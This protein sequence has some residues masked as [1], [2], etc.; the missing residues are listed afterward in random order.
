MEVKNAYH[1]TEEGWRLSYAD[2]PTGTAERAVSELAWSLIMA[3]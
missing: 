2:R 3:G 1:P